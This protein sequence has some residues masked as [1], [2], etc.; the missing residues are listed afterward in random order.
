MEVYGLLLLTFP[1]KYGYSCNKACS[2]GLQPWLV[3]QEAHILDKAWHPCVCTWTD[4]WVPLEL[5]LI[6]ILLHAGCL[7]FGEVCGPDLAVLFPTV[8][9]G[10]GHEKDKLFWQWEIPFDRHVSWRESL[11]HIWRVIEV[12]WVH[13]PDCIACSILLQSHGGAVVHTRF[14]P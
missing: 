7:E 2:C 4:L 12:L 14:L 6:F 10:T 5:F 8:N 1:L 3:L 13:V 11:L 9:L